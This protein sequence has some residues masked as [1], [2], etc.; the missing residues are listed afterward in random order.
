MQ[1]LK[2]MARPWV[3]QEPLQGFEQRSHMLSQFNRAPGCCVEN[4]LQEGHDGS[5]NTS[6]ERGDVGD[7]T[8]W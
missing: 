3:R 7:H 8:R 5:W 1:N 4:R 6:E 2:V